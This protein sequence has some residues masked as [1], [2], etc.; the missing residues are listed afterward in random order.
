MKKLFKSFFYAGRGIFFG[1][2]ER[3][4]KIHL[5]MTVIVVLAGIYF[6]LKQAEWLVILLL[7]ALVMSAELNN[8][9]IEELANKIRDELK[10]N[11]QATTRARDTAAGAVF[12]NA[13]IAAIIGLMIFLPKILHF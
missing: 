2:A 13:M 3:N 1:L 10:L 8:T 7:F 12:L 4:M 6:S 9:A 5:L 11:Y